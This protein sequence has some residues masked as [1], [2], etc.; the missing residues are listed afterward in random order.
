MSRQQNVQQQ[1][2]QTFDSMLKSA[3]YFREHGVS[4]GVEKFFL[5]H[6]IDINAAA[7]IFALTD[8]Y[9]M[10]FSFGIRGLIVTEKERFFSFELELDSSLN[11]V[12]FVHEFEEVTAEQNLIL[13]NK[14]SGKGNGQIALDVLR[15]VNAI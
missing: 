2:E 14:G 9:M 6:N 11:E 7:I 12:V 10:G 1:N 8:G 5:E 15:T 3:R 13:N 4:R